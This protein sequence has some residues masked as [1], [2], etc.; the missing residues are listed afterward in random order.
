MGCGNFRQL[1]DAC[2]GKS[3][4]PVLFKRFGDQF[5]RLADAKQSVGRRIDRHD[6]FD[7]NVDVER[8]ERL[9]FVLL[10]ERNDKDATRP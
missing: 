6:V 7:R 5:R 1:I 8:V 9:K 3:D 2:H 10:N 4:L